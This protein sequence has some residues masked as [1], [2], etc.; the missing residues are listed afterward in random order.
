MNRLLLL[1]PILLLASC[2]TTVMTKGVAPPRPGGQRF[3]HLVDDDGAILATVDHQNGDVSYETSC[4]RRAFP[5][6]LAVTESCTA[7]LQACRNPAPKP[8][9]EKAEKKK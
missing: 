1:V 4:E 2:A 7:Q 9:P 6:L 3:D 8:E 5:R